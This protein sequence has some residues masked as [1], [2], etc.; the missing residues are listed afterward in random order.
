MW[1]NSKKLAILSFLEYNEAILRQIYYI[2]KVS[3]FQPHQPN[4]VIRNDMSTHMELNMLFC[5]YIR[6]GIPKFILKKSCPYH[7]KKIEGKLF[8]EIFN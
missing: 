1:S 7:Q 6:T 2:L 4:F 3:Y 5:V 8:E